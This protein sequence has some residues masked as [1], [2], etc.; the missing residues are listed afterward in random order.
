MKA[1]NPIKFGTDGWRAVI[2]QEF[3]FDNVRICAQALA[4]HL[5]QSGQAE[6]GIVIGY[7]TRFASEDFAAACACVAAAN[8]IKVYLSPKAI[9]TPEASFGVT[10][11]NAAAAIVITASHNPAQYN[12]FKLKSADG[13]SAPDEMIAAVEQETNRIYDSGEIRISPWMKHL[14]Q[15][16]VEY[17]DFDPP[18]FQRFPVL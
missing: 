18:Y 12:G 7:D 10:A 8:D 15:E 14:K 11:K 16:R 1:L 3:T 4:D 6:K 9:P 13:A 5:K 2:A 17:F